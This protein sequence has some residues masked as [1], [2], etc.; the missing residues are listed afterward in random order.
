[1]K[2]QSLVDKDGSGS[3]KLLLSVALGLFAKNG[4]PGTTVED[5]VNKAG[6]TKGAFY[7]YFQSKEEVLEIIHN[8]YI[9]KQIVLCNKVC[10]DYQDP[11]EQIRHIAKATIIN[12]G[13]YRANVSVYLQERRFLS[14]ARRK[15]VTSKRKEVDQIFTG[16][17]E[18]GVEYGYFRPDLAPKI[19]AFG[20]I[21]MYAWVINWWKPDGN[22]SLEDIADQYVNLL[23]RGLEISK[24]AS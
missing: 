8:D 6:L 17:I 18:R 7:Y 16:I 1:M 20:I 22:L 4:Y 19:I 12:L 10:A 11:R 23:L 9:E 14:G 13:E 15:V 3:K 2:A 21:G 5:I 24:T